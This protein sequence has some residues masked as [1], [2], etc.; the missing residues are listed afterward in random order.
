VSTSGTAPAARV[1]TPLPA[2]HHGRPI[3]PQPRLRGQR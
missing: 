2:P 1:I 3:L